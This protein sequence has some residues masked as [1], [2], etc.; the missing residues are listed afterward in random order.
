MSAAGESGPAEAGRSREP[1]PRAYT[2]RERSRSHTPTEQRSASASR[3]RSRSRSRSRSPARRDSG[4]E[5]TAP[6]PKQHGSGEGK[7]ES[8]DKKRR[9]FLV[10]ALCPDNVMISIQEGAW[11]VP[12]GLLEDKLEAAYASGETRLLIVV[13]DSM[14]FSGW[15]VMRG[16]VGRLG[17][18]VP[19]AVSCAGTRKL[20][21]PF[22]VAWRC[23]YDLPAPE[24]EGI[25]NAM[26][27]NRPV[28]QV[29]QEEL[30]FPL[31]CPFIKAILPDW[32]SPVPPVP[33][34]RRD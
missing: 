9:Y 18:H 16:R 34:G 24:L 28:L 15:A 33:P 21:G 22:A 4:E 3:Q 5:G 23:L 27:G 12:A 1:S 14:C 20:G 19:W 32:C 25:T 8:K 13:A 6:V 11:A 10:R 30:L 7:K 29:R 17:K 26:D 31:W 2:P